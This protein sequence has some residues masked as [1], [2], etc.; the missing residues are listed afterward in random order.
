LGLDYD[1]LAQAS[2]DVQIRVFKKQLDLI[3]T[4]GWRLP[5]FLHCR[6]AY[7]DFITI[8]EPYMDRLPL[9]SGLVHSFVGT[10]QQMQ[11]LVTLG[12]H[13]SVNSFG[14]RDCE[15]LEMVQKIPLDKLQIETDAP[16]GEI[17]V[18][19]EVSKA[20]LENATK[21][22]WGSKKKDK[23]KVGDMVKE[24]NESCA[25]E[26]VVMIVAGIKGVGVDEVAECA[27]RNSMGMFFSFGTGKT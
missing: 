7:E 5:L 17:Q 24:R 18:S 2:K 9:R 19:S 12:L 22:P 14:F 1:K 26:K 15:S 11:Q 4:A 16:W 6:A 13:V 10:T 25:M 21:W 20:Y 27:W 8:L 3:V 23:F